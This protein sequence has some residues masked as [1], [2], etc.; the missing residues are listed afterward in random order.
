MS[1][2]STSI[3]VLAIFNSHIN[4]EDVRSTKTVSASFNMQN[5]F[6]PDEKI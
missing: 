2:V 3:F 5:N 6:C 4:K 1:Y